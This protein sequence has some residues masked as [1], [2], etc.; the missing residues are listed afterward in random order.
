MPTSISQSS[1]L[2]IWVRLGEHHL[3]DKLQEPL[4]HVEIEVEI[5]SIHSGYNSR[6]LHNDIAVL[7]LKTPLRTTTK[8][9][10]HIAPICLPSPIEVR[11]FEVASSR[12]SA[13]G[14]KPCTTT[15]WG[16]SSSPKGKGKGK[17]ASMSEVLKKVP[18]P[19]VESTRCERLLRRTKLGGRF[20]LHSSFLCAGGEAGVDAC[21]GDGGS[22]LQCQAEDG[23]YS[24]VGLTSWGVGCGERAV[25]GVYT[26][27]LEFVDFIEQSRQLMA[28]EEAEEVLGS[29]LDN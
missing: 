17:V 19:L 28:E 12:G 5:I 10:A 15:G 9:T 13:G 6:N 24:L 23:A 2:D 7:R 26:N 25:P 21:L 11:K 8:D 22:A 29:L 18:L 4:P 3:G 1:T 27:V 14:K 16:L 20:Q